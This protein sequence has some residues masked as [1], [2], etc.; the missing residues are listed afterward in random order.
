MIQ[1]NTL[2]LKTIFQ[3]FKKE[4]HMNKNSCWQYVKKQIAL[5]EDLKMF[6]YSSLELNN[7]SFDDVIFEYIDS[8]DKSN[9]IRVKKFIE[10]YEWLEKMPSRPT[11]RFIAKYKDIVI[12]VIV[13]AT[14]YTFSNI[15]GR[16]NKHLEKLIARGATISWAPKNTGSWLIMKSIQWM[17]QHTEF[18]VFS[19]YSDIEANELGTIYQACNF[20]YLGQNSGGRFE[21]IDPKT[22]KKMSDRV[23]RRVG[24]YKKYAR[25]LGISWDKSWSEKWKMNWDQVPNE[26]ITALKLKSKEHEQS[27]I[28]ISVP[29][30]HKYILIK[31][32]DNRETKFLKSLFKKN[33][34]NIRY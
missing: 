23:F 25:D 32:R 17:V 3:L 8:S 30:K 28:K 22:N 21:F 14:P 9:C 10:R 34:R 4:V 16:N 13:M 5:K 26:I 15:I 2:L 1:K 12:G 31:G 18:R 24:S 6:P 19:G 20:I 33:L 7:I 27:C 11:H 29:K